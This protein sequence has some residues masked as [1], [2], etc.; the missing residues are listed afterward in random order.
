[1]FA[2][3]V[4]DRR[5]ATAVIFGL[6]ALPLLGA[7][8]A[9]LDYSRA[10]DL[11]SFLQRETDMAA[12]AIASSD[13]PNTETIEAGL[14]SRAQT[15]FGTAGG[16]NPVQSVTVESSWQGSSILTVTANTTFKPTLLSAVPGMPATLNVGTLTKVSRIPA[17]WI[18]ELPQVS[19]L[20]YEA[21]DYNQVGVYCY[22]VTKKTNTNKGRR[23]ETLKWIADNGGTDFDN[24]S[25]QCKVGETVA[26]MLHNVRNVRGDSRKW[27][28]PTQDHYLY[29]TDTEID[30]NTRVMANTVTGGKAIDYN[31]NV[32][33]TDLTNA[34]ILETIICDSITV[35]KS[36]QG[37]VL[38]ALNQKNRDPQ[39]A[40]GACSEGKYVYYGWEDRPR[41]SNNS[42]DANWG[43]KDYDD[44]R[45]IVSCPKQKQLTNKQVKIIQ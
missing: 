22:D 16:R 24:T 40:T 11:R 9:A 25:I 15:H 29:F 37:G 38:P 39:T 7:V 34:P 20:D 21:G 8:G 32:T 5:G 45:L 3:W 43:D 17:E 10:A 33:P 41:L 44:I 30:P 42:N 13:T 12:L 27:M 19:M 26:Y 2:D 31:Y 4:S 14:T 28:D 35:C 6:A 36:G 18:W 1:M 23:M